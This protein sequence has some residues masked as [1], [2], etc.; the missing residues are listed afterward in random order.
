MLNDVMLS[1]QLETD[2]TCGAAGDVN[3]IKPT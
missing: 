3:I 1:L 2:V